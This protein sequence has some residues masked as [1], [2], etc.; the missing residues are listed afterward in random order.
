MFPESQWILIGVVGALVIFQLIFFVYFFCFFKKNYAKNPST[1]SFRKQKFTINDSKVEPARLSS[2]DESSLE[3]DNQN[4]NDIKLRNSRA[5]SS[6]NKN[7]NIVSN[8]NVCFMSNYEFNLNSFKY[9]MHPKKNKIDES[10]SDEFSEQPIRRA[11]RPKRSKST[12]DD[13]QMDDLDTSFEPE[14]MRLEI[15]GSPKSRGLKNIMKDETSIQILNEKRNLQR[16]RAMSQKAPLK[17]SIKEDHRRGG[18]NRQLTH[19]MDP[20]E[21]INKGGDSQVNQI[22]KKGIQKI[23]F[24][25]RSPSLESV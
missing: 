1:K 21:Y 5:K 11:A 13:I 12:E 2:A 16:T 4:T 6:K 24:K 19:Q 14:I 17:E 8:L 9:Q 22:K 20:Y 10:L 3:L 23:K 25:R 18:R 15:P 7:K